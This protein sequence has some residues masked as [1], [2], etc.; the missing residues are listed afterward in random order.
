[1]EAIVELRNDHK[2]YGENVALDDLSL[3][4]RRG[5]F[6]TLLGPSGSGKTTI[7]RLVAGFEE[8]QAGQI[9]SRGA[10]RRSLAALSPQRQ[11]GLSAL[12]AF[13]PPRRFPQ[14]GVRSGTE[15]AAEGRDTAPRL[16]DAGIGGST[17]QGGARARCA[18]GPRRA[19]RCMMA[20]EQNA[21]AGWGR[22]QTTG[23]MHGR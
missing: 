9:L 5:E 2:S 15:K 7:L 1:M 6:L 13:S 4:L 17:G 11:H 21:A 3:E 8:P 16:L 12:C 10:G 18:A 23:V 14:R 19:L 22:A 20:G